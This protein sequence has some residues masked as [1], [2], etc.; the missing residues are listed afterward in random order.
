VASDSAECRE[1][2]AT[3]ENA[4][5]RWPRPLLN[6]PGRVSNLDRDKLH[7]LLAG[8]KGLEIPATVG[9]TRAQLS[10]LSVEQIWCE[11]I[12]ADL[13]FPMI[14]RPRGTH[15]G[16]GLAKIDD[17]T[18]LVDYLAQRDEQEFFVARF[19]DYSS[20]DGLFRKYRLAIVEGQPFAVHM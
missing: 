19:V 2:L 10:E 1:A 8:I 9:A 14:V 17:A 13:R 12:A 7:R 15:A 4:A 3:I 5:P 11:D 6:H 18:A 20:P 16:V